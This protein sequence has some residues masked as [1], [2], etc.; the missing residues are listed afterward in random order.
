MDV[1]HPTRR[2]RRQVWFPETSNPD[3]ELSAASVDLRFQVRLR[4]GDDFSVDLADLGRPGLLR[5]FVQVLW[6]ICQIGGPAGSRSTA[7]H[8]A[9]A[10]RRFWA[11]LDDRYPV[12]L[13]P[14]HLTPQHVN[15]FESWLRD[16]RHTEISAYQSWP[17]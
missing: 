4:Y 13:R 5:P 6:R 17:S 2:P 1:A 11:F 10:V 3:V 16:G 14:E 12:F 15:E 9:T 8:Y 7:Q